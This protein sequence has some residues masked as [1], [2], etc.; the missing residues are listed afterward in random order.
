MFR[1]SVFLSVTLMAL[2]YLATNPSMLLAQGRARTNMRVVTPMTTPMSR[3]NMGVNSRLMDPRFD[4]FRPSFDQR[5]LDQRL[6]NSRFD[7][8]NPLLE[9]RSLDPRL[10]M[11]NPTI[12]QLLLERRFSGF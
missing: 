9:R 3:F 7:R 2:F 8:F 1:K 5:I 4:R 12:N 6:L 10:N 11:L